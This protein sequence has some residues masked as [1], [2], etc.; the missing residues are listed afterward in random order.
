M[1]AVGVG[2]DGRGTV[3]LARGWRGGIFWPGLVFGGCLMHFRLLA[4]VGI[5]ILN[6]E[7][8]QDSQIHVIK[9][10]GNL[11]TGKPLLLHLCRHVLTCIVH[12]R[13]PCWLQQLLVLF[14]QNKPATNNQPAVLFSRNKS[15]PTISHQPN[16][17]TESLNGCSV[18][19]PSQNK[20]ISSFFNVVF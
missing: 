9:D 12:M 3:V 10:S 4:L 1:A 8:R 5:G 20:C 19:F 16:E 2:E 14:S 17:H 18:L 7:A 11:M 13:P 6:W 15:T